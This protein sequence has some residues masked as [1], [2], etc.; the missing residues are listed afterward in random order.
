MGENCSTGPHHHR[1]RMCASAMTCN[2][3][4]FDGYGGPVH[5]HSRGKVPFDDSACCVNAHACYAWHEF[6]L[7]VEVDFPRDRGN[8]C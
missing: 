8:F 6:P 7:C 3:G 4:A 2:V 1:A 5:E